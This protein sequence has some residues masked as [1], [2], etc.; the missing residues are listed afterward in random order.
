MH[1][2]IQEAMKKASVAWLTAP[3]VSGGYAVWCLWL[4][5]ALYL[6]TG[7]GEQPAPGLV[8]AGTVDVSARGD[9]GGRIVTW[10]AAVTRVEP[11]G[12]EWETIAPQLAAKR[13]NAPGAVDGT[14][15]RW[16]ATCRVYRLVP[17]ADPVEAGAD[18]SDASGAAPPRPTPATNRTP[19]P[20]RL[21]RV[22]GAR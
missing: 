15:A 18:L 17:V 4:E 8:E 2:L 19:K 3:G 20:F 22:R 14:V 6:V 1:P 21:H 11:G 12:P 13:L 16:A 9:H 10:P 5:D 7:D